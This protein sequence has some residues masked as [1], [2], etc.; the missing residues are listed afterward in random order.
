MP[1]TEVQPTEFSLARQEIGDAGLPFE[2]DQLFQCRLTQVRV[3]QQ[4]ALALLCLRHR[5][6]KSD[7]GLA[8]ARQRA[9]H[10]NALPASR[11]RRRVSCNCEGGV[12]LEEE[13]AIQARPMLVKGTER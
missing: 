9:R 6:G 13:A 2:L 4:R 5:Q 8:L 7:C 12:H 1:G 3:D 10:Q 11:S